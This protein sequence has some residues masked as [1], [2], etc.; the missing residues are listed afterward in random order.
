[1]IGVSVVSMLLKID[2]IP[3]GLLMG[4]VGQ[5]LKVSQKITRGSSDINCKILTTWSAC[6]I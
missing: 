6:A 5:L 4:L 1:M 3:C 2:P